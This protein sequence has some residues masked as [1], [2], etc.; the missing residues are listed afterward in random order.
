MA[1]ARFNSDFEMEPAMSA[2][3]EP[4]GY[5]R[6]AP[7]GNLTWIME[8]NRFQPSGRIKH[9]ASAHAVSWPKRLRSTSGS[10]AAQRA[11]P[12]AGSR[13]HGW[14]ADRE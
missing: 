5:S 12:I 8:T 10:I 4:S 1:I 6:S 3:R 9:P 7:S 11:K 13:P 14:V 2:P